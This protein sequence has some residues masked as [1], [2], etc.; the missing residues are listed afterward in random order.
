MSFLIGCAPPPPAPEGL[1]ESSSYMV[2]N[3]YADDETFKAGVQSFMDWFNS[4]GQEILGITADVNSTDAFEVEPLQL[5]DVA[6][7]PLDP[8]IIT[9]ARDD[10]IEARDTT[11]A[12]G[13]VSLAEMDCSWTETEALLV[14]PDQD[15]V[16]SGDWEGYERT[17]VTPMDTFTEGSTSSDFADI[18]RNLEPFAEDF[19]PAPYASSL[20][21]TDNIVDPTLV[22][23]ANIESYPMD[24]D[25][26]HTTVDIDGEQTGVLAVLTYNRAAAWGA[27]G[28]AALLQS[29]SIELNIER[30]GGRTLRLLAVWAE[31]FDRSNLVAPDSPLAKVFAVNK[32][33]DSSN[34]I[35]AI[36]SGDIV[37]P[38]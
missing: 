23:T 24:L 30:P 9:D 21:F 2:R 19:D 34:R 25:L 37:L 38:D 18:R 35:S 28:Q 3:F 10:I 11:R 5:D 17:Y 26:R 14:R 8:E 33:L 13:V 29:Y 22:V 4:E 7:L 31:T 16:F 15:T 6:H 32:S 27:S 20:L 36:C 12:V 1:N